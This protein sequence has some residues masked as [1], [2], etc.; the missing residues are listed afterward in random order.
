MN[1]EDVLKTILIIL[2]ATALWMSWFFYQKF[3]GR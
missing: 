3:R 2:V 1:A